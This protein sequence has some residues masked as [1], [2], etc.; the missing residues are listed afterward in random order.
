MLYFIHDCPFPKSAQLS[1]ACGLSRLHLEVEEKAW[2]EDKSG[3]VSNILAF[4]RVAQGMGYYLAWLSANRTGIAGM[5]GAGWWGWKQRRVRVACYSI[6]G[7][8]VSQTDKRRR[9]TCCFALS[10]ETEEQASVLCSSFS[11][12][13]SQG[14]V[15]VLPNL[16]MYRELAYFGCP[17]ATENK[18]S[19]ITCSCNTRESAVSRLTPESTRDYKVLKKKPTSVFNR[20]TTHTQA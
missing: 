16:G 3:S 20:E 11:D 15:L 18:E 12:S 2:E 13:Q 14:L 17:G 9:P 1:L 10:G 4:Q 6:R 8:T 19:R 7:P 5:T